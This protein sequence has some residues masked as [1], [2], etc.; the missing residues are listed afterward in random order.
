MSRQGFDP[1]SSSVKELV[2]FM[3]YIENAEGFDQ[4]NWPNMADE[5]W[6]KQNDA[7]YQTSANYDQSSRRNMQNK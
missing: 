7:A 6:Q 4:D 5:N 3:E 1:M 2:S